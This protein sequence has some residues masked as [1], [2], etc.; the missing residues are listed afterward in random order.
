M[1]VFLTRCHT[2]RHI[3]KLFIDDSLTYESTGELPRS[4]QVL[5]C[6]WSS[7]KPTQVLCFIW[8]NSQSY[9]KVDLPQSPL[10]MLWDTVHESIVLYG[11]AAPKYSHL[12]NCC[13][14]SYII[15][16]TCTLI[17]G[18]VM[19]FPNSLVRN[20]DSIITLKQ[21]CILDTVTE[22]RTGFKTRLKTQLKDNTLLTT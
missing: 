5:I 4:S 22:R 18:D 19:S 1:L 3:M 16:K 13:K 14:N 10:C 9:G 6:E 11:C 7:Y 2:W 12:A 20:L 21:W 15:R 17:S 8:I